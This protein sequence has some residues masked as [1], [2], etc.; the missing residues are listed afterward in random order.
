MM[1]TESTPSVVICVPTAG[2]RDI[3][4]LLA[5][6]VR[7]VGTLE[8]KCECRLELIDNS[9]ESLER[10]PL[11]ALGIEVRREATPGYSSARNA[12]LEAAGGADFLIF[13]DDDE[14]PEPEWLSELLTPALSGKADVVFGPVRTE[15]P[16]GSARWLGGGETLRNRLWEQWPEGSSDENV[17]SGN[18]LISMALV[19]SDPP[20]RFDTSLNCLGGEDTDFFH[21]LRAKGA[22]VHW[23][24][25]AL[26]REIPDADR[27]AFR[28][29]LRRSWQA[30]GRAFEIERLRLGRQRAS[31]RALRR[32]GRFAGGMRLV[33][34]GILHSH[35]ASTARGFSEFSFALGSI[36][37]CLCRGFPRARPAIGGE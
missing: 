32:M 13:I 1:N 20:T 35:P 6:L 24:P 5:A 28:G 11:S 34:L 19:R 8:L 37:R 7:Q 21:R 36:S 2:R 18:T 30:G 12:A 9:R 23:A 29:Y 16:F 14:R 25:R 31:F 17:Y 33:I 10:A 27:L 15:V 4:E 22:R 26:V 3:Q